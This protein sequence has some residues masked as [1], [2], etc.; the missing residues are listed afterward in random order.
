MTLII[1]DTL[2]AVLTY[3]LT[4]LNV[5]LSTIYLSSS[6][7]FSKISCTLLLV[8]VN[9]RNRLTGVF[10]RPLLVALHNP[11]RRLRL[12]LR[13]HISHH[14]TSEQGLHWSRGS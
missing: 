10:V 2:I 6:R 12:L 4:S 7:Y 11:R 14:Q 5:A 3:L 13:T 8:V 9:I 1:T